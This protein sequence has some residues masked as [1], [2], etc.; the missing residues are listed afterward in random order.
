MAARKVTRG[1]LY[2]H[3]ADKQDL[4]RAVH[5][6]LEEEL[7]ATIVEQIAGIDDRGRAVTGM[8]AF[9]D[10]ATD[11]AASADRPTSTR[12]PCSA[13][14]SGARSTRSTASGS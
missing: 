14:R 9:L 6:Q 8:R 3:F 4:F 5:E 7:V 12:R 10:R 13:G 1:A 2:H 11:P